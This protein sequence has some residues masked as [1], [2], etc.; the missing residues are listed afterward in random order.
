MLTQKSPEAQAGSMK[1]QQINIKLHLGNQR[2][3]KHS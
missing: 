1:P 2:K 3:N